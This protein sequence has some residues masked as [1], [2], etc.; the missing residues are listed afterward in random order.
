MQSHTIFPSPKNYN[1]KRVISEISQKYKITISKEEKIQ[2]CLIESIEYNQ[3][4]QVAGA[5]GSNVKV[6]LLNGWI[7]PIGGVA[8]RRV[9]Y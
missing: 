4:I 6:I 9:C 2:G 3:C 7:L 5:V 8:L 1:Y